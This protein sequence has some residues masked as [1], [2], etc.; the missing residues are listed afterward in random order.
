MKTKLRTILL[1]AVAFLLVAFAG[2]RIA[3]QAFAVMPL[4]LHLFTAT[5]EHY[6][7]ANEIETIHLVDHVG[8]TSERSSSQLG[9]SVR[10]ESRSAFRQNA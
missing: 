7:V 2:F 4:N 8:R 6:T 9:C 3:V 5:V 10:H 1:L